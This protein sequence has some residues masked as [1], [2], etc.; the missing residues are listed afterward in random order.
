[1][2]ES[3]LPQNKDKEVRSPTNEEIIKMLNFIGDMIGLSPW[4]SHFGY[5]KFHVVSFTDKNKNDTENE[6]KD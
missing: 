5:G 4:G 6:T 3:Y 1:M 2:N